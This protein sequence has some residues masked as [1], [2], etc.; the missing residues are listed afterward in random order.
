MTARPDRFGPFLGA[1]EIGLPDLQGHQLELAPAEVRP[2]LDEDDGV[3][4][5]QIG[6]PVEH[7]RKGD[8]GDAAGEI[9]QAEHRIGL[10][11]PGVAASDSSHDARH[12]HHVTVPE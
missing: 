2:S 7:R 10:A 6:D 8:D 5:D 4:R 3:V 9:L 1:G 12:R 11:A